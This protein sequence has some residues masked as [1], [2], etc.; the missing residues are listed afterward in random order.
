MQV[1]LLD[2]DRAGAAQ[3]AAGLAARGIDVTSRAALRDVGSLAGAAALVVATPVSADEWRA[4]CEAVA[5]CD[6]A[7]ALLLVDRAGQAGELRRALP[8]HPGPDAVLPPAA[9]LPTLVVAIGESLRGRGRAAP[10]A[11]LPDLLA[12]LAALRETGVL[13]LRAED[14]CTRILIREGAPVFAEG[15]A[16]RET[17]GRLLLRRGALSEADYV[18]VIE[19]MTAR[20]IENEAT[21]MGEVLIEL[22]LL[23]PQE[24]FEALSEQVRDKILCCFRWS[25]FEHHFEPRGALPD[26]VLAYRCPPVEALVLAGVREHFDEARLAPLLAPVRGARLRLRASAEEIAARF[27]ATPAEQRLLRDLDGSR[28]CEAL[29]AASPLGSAHAGQVLA[30]LVVLDAVET[31]ADDAARAAPERAR[32][33]PAPRETPPHEAVARETALPRRTKAAPFSLSQ[34][35]RELARQGKAL[36]PARAPVDARTAALEAERAFRQGLALLAQPALP[37]A[38]RAFA[39]A[40]EGNPDEPEYA[41]MAAWVETLLAKEDAAR[42]AARARAAEHARRLLKHDPDSARAHDVLGQIAIAAGE[43]DAAERHFRHVLRAA[44]EHRDALRGM[45]TVERRRAESARKR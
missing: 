15:G 44:P 10:T 42:A 31:V 20:L 2:A 24:V 32:S 7:P 12:A 27:A 45:R 35:R 38:R 28:T 11:T 40:C 25:R 1:T 29:R 26:D 6:P 23:T 19:R 33:A 22:G 13:E 4:A 36:A 37:G 30:A 18:R 41:L 17:L 43:L 39:R 14:L 34:L 16:L 8:G 21:R 5:D 3:L 9:L